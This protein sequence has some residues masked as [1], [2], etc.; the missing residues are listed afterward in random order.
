MI[1]NRAYFVRKNAKEQMLKDM[2]NK[3]RKFNKSF[4][5]LGI[6]AAVILAMLSV[7]LLMSIYWMFK[8]WNSLTMD[9]LLFHLTAPLEG[10]NSNG[11][12]D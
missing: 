10:T 1:Y 4:K 8:T 11:F 7:L 9:E 5:A 2:D 6:I 12:W 3:K